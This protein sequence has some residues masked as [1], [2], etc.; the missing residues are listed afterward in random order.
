MC[1]L[2]PAPLL[3]LSGAMAFG[4]ALAA[5]GE[6]PAPEYRTRP[7]HMAYVF[8]WFRSPDDP[9]QIESL[10]VDLQLIG[11]LPESPHLFVVPLNGGLNETLFYFG[12]MTQSYEVSDGDGWKR[13]RSPGFV[14]TR[15][16]TMSREYVRPAKGGHFLASDHEGEHVSARA[17]GRVAG[18]RYTFTLK[19]VE[20]VADEKKPH[21]WVG[22]YVYSHATKQTNH[23][24][25]L[26]FDGAELTQR[27][28][29]GSFLEVLADEDRKKNLSDAMPEMKVA[30]GRWEI[31]GKRAKPVLMWGQYLEKVPQK[32]RAVLWDKAPEADLKGIAEEMREDQT[33]IIAMRDKPFSREGMRR[34]EEKRKRPTGEPVGWVKRETLFKLR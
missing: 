20:K 29:I 9:H 15:W 27:Y 17:P 12:V 1:S 30:V 11:D 2:R 3:L 33:F 18:G 8:A 26:R 7:W 14:F 6:P 21:V 13:V 23:V 24:G 10:S 28:A 22:G 16:G 4:T 19:V 32:A 31:D 34:E 5:F 25:D